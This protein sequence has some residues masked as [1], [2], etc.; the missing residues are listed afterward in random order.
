MIK[1]LVAEDSTAIREL[2][3]MNL[4][5]AG[6]RVDCA[7]DGMEAANLI[8]E[9]RYDLIL[10][11]IMMPRVDG[12]ELMEYIRP[13]DIPVIFITAKGEVRDRVK[14]LKMGA[15]DYIVKPFE[16]AELLAR[17]ESVLRR[18]YK[19]ATLLQVE[20][21]SIDT[22][23]RVVTQNGQQVPLTT[24]EYELLLLFVKNK[25]IALFRDFIYEKVWQSSDM[26]DTRTL[27]LHVQRLR[28]KLHW[29]QKIKAVYKVGY[30]LEVD[31]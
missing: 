5:Q 17:V 24:K 28:K 21:V 19:G 27:D 1:I 31:A 9:S 2:I 12:Y 26:G 8:E 23:S 15:D 10:L 6:Y 20:T 11:D 4:C 22:D 30:R 16:I 3:E 14:G 13:L 7:A 29:E 18:Y 25:N